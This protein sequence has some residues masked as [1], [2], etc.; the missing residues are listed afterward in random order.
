M[1]KGSFLFKYSM[2]PGGPTW[3]RRGFG[4]ASYHVNFWFWSLASLSDLDSDN[5][6]EEDDDD[7]IVITT[8]Y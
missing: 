3:P 2:I 7:V 5:V 6:E 4:K 8:T 1:G